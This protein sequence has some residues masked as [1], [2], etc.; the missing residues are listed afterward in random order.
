MLRFHNYD[1]VFQEVPGEV[2]L[3]INITN[4]PNG[5]KGCHSTHLQKDTGELLDET[6]LT[7]LLD[8][9]GETIT[10]ICFMGGDREPKEVERL[11][12]LVR[13]AT[14]GRLKCAWYSGKAEFPHE[15]SVQSFDYVK[16]GPYREQFGGLDSP[17]TNQ[18]FYR[19][20]NGEMVD[21]T[22]R[23]RAKKL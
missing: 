3:A 11:S 21:I 8:K 2:T 10:C 4:C 5:C 20:E 18:R 19:V 13:Q 17:T 14:N 16:L 23:F 6:T 9:Y 15:C 12:L 7:A 22:F 1:I